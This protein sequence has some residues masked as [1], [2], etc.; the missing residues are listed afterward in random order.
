MTVNASAPVLSLVTTVGSEADAQ[1]LARTLVERRLAACV[2]VDPAITSHYRWDG[3]LCAE[4]E[5]RLVVKSL[6]QHL[7]RLQ[8]FFRAEHPYALPQLLWQELQASPAYADW[9]RQETL[10]QP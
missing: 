2:Q 1:R 9:V 8:D 5:W 7:D 3:R 4:P 10:S 6:P